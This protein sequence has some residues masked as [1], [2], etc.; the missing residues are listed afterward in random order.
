MSA[1]M[2]R[3]FWLRLFLAGMAVVCAASWGI[4]GAL[5]FGWARR[6]LLARLAVSFGRPVDVGHFEFSLLSGPQLE[7]DSVSVS[8]DPRFGQEYFLRAEQLRAGL[9]WTALLRG[10][11]EFGTLSLIHPSLNLV[12]TKDGHWNIE[13][14]LP[15]DRAAAPPATGV[16]TDSAG[17]PRQAGVQIAGGPV[18]ER[19]QHIDVDNGRINFKMEAD[20]LPFALIDVSGHLDHDPLGRWS[21]DLTANP[22]RTSV[23]LQDAGMLR[24]RGTI[25]GTSERLWPAAL[26]LNWDSAS[27]ADAMRLSS[28][29][30]FGVR[31]V[32]AAELT[33]K[34]AAPT[35]DA[36]KSARAVWTIGGTLPAVPRILR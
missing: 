15:S 18:A 4:S 11:V 7:A 25:A 8:E 22:M 34:I 36:A 10:R 33:A 26:T 14:W 1:I 20:K 27:L 12:H 2:K 35:P 21:L 16:G 6:S 29:R 19:L 13:S 17:P 3:R 30:D 28:G 31:G 23:A 5:A 9:R 32:L 24:L